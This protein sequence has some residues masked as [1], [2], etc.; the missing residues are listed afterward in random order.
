MTDWTGW[1]H[2]RFEYRALSLDMQPIGLLDGV[3]AGSCSLRGSIYADIRWSGDLSWSGR[4]SPDWSRLLVHPHYV[5]D[6]QAYP[7]CPP[8]HARRP[9]ITYASAVSESSSV[10]LYDVTY[11]VQAARLS[12]AV[13]YPA[14]TPITATVAERLAA[15]GITRMAIAPSPA[16]LASPMSWD[17]NTT[18]LVVI[19]NLLAAAGYWSL[20]ADPS[21]ALAGA[22]YVNPAQQ[23]A[24][25]DYRPGSRSTYQSTHTWTRDDWDVP[26]RLTGVSR[27]GVAVTVTLDE[28]DAQSPYAHASRGMWVDGDTLRD[29]DAA[30][31]AALR[32]RVVAEMLRDT[33][34]ASTREVKHAWMPGVQLGRVVTFAPRDAVVRHL[35]TNQAI[36]LT[37]GLQSADV[38][39]EVA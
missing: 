24:V 17:I 31:A 39:R 13:S 20:H 30:D 25:Y 21:G 32:S 27:D 18:E 5:V 14:G 34:V 11:R 3:E 38:W 37:T 35:V 2:E 22:P 12:Q 15:L 36:K 1:R 16:V 9:S 26:N 28:L 6:G 23:V 4:T 7:L 8:L 29:V 33:S 10:Q 19:N